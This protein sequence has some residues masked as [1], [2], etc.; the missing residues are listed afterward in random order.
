MR[1][2]IIKTKDGKT[3]TVQGNAQKIFLGVVT[4][5]ANNEVVHTVKLSELVSF[6]MV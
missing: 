4:I 2:F 3:T 5:L 6:Q 1:D